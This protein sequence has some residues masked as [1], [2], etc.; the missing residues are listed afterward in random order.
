MLDEALILLKTDPRF[1][2]LDYPLIPVHVSLSLK[3]R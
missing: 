1:A 2:V 3:H